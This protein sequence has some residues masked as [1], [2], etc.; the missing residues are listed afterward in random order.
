MTY[1]LNPPLTERELELV[2]EL[3]SRTNVANA[4]ARA[5]VELGWTQQQVGSAAGTKQSRISELEGLQ[6][7]VRF[8]TLDRIARV[9]GLM[10]DLVARPSVTAHAN[11]ATSAGP[12]RGLNVARD[13]EG[14]VTAVELPS[15]WANGISD[16]VVTL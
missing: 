12:Y 2:E 8:D 16:E 4:I 13:T 15:V 1:E 14:A 5:R 3:R 11:A 6:G 10:I 7:N 9:L